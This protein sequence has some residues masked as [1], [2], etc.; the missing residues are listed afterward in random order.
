M[1]GQYVCCWNNECTG[2][3]SWNHRTRTSTH[4]HVHTWPPSTMYVQAAEA[5]LPKTFPVLLPFFSFVFTICIDFSPCNAQKHILNYQ[6][7]R[8]Y[9]NAQRLV[10]LTHSKYL[11]SYIESREAVETLR[12]YSRWCQSGR[13]L[14]FVSAIAFWFSATWT[15]VLILCMRLLFNFLQP[16]RTH[17]MILFLRLLFGFLR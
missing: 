17:F 11:S 14:N 13:M 6:L 3:H 15:H 5:F 10:S 2:Y 16:G 7:W 1:D 4:S 9:L 8:M 12:C